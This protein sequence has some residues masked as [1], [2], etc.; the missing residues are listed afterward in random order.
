MKQKD[1]I[2]VNRDAAPAWLRRWAEAG[3][4]VFNA[5]RPLPGAASEVGDFRHGTFYTAV[6]PGLPLADRVIQEIRDLDGWPVV[7]IGNAEIQAEVIE[8]LA[9]EIPLDEALESLGGWPQ[10]AWA[11]GWPWHEAK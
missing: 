4:P 9:D 1:T 7:L 10:L 8:H 3:W 6:D 11:A 5:P 2:Y